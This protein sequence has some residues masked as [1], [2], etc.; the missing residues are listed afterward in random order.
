MFQGD[1]YVSAIN[2]W[3]EKLK[4]NGYW[5][6]YSSDIIYKNDLFTANLSK[7]YN[8]SYCEDHNDGYILSEKTGK[9]VKYEMTGWIG[10]MLFFKTPIQYRIIEPKPCL[11]IY[12]E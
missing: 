2:I 10:K 3:Y 11:I 4:T 7:V 5:L 8:K 12:I 9:F 6:L 1:D